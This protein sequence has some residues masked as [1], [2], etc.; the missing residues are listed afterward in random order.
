MTIFTKVVLMLS[1]GAKD[2]LGRVM[3]HIE[4]GAFK[5]SN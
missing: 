5:A 2:A 4:L 1:D 3:I